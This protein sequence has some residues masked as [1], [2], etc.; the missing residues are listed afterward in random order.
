MAEGCG[1]A[2][3]AWRRN[4]VSACGSSTMTKTARDLRSEADVYQVALINNTHLGGVVDGAPRQP[5]QRDLERQSKPGGERRVEWR[6]RT[7][8]AP[9]QGRLHVGRKHPDKGREC[10]VA[11]ESWPRPAGEKDGHREFD[12]S[13]GVGRGPG[14]TGHPCGDDPVELGGEHEVGDACRSKYRDN[15][16]TRGRTE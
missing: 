7:F 4:R 2:P 16:Y 9:I 15:R 13:A 14:T 8:D 6:W 12:R 1:A 5:Q 3:C 10:Q 11:G